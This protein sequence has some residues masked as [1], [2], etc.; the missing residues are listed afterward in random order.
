VERLDALALTGATVYREPELEPL[1][2]SAVLLR[3]GKIAAVGTRADIAIPDDTRVIDCD[4]CIIT[5]G[6]CNAHVH[7]HERK[8]SDVAAIPALELARQLQDITR[9]RVTTCF[10]LSSPLQNTDRLR[11]RIDS[12]EVRGP[13]I[14][15][16]GEGLIPVGGAPSADAFRALGL[17]PAA[18]REVADAT[19]ARDAVR[20]LLEGGADAIKLFLSSPTAGALTFETV[21]AAIDEAH[22]AG[23]LV[24][25]HPNTASDVLTGVDAG[26]DVIAHTTPRSGAWD[27]NLIRAMREHGAALIPTLMLWNDLMRH[28]RLSVREQLAGAAVEQ[29]RAWRELDG[30]VLFGTDLGAVKYD[31][32]EEYQLMAEA[33]MAVPQ[34]LASLTT[35]PAHLLGRASNRGEIRAGGVADIVVL[36]VARLMDARDLASV[37][38]TICAGEIIYEAS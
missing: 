35:S 29:L 20:S 27:A 4:G 37:R 7:F 16:T 17:M 32:T 15:T 33:G 3:N 19:R 5:P 25:A 8:W 26:V 18:L 9:Y 2:D 10:D 14:L 23:K 21:R 31:P 1:H 28:D 36:G 6:F 30:T 38:F 34:I 13:R 12:R 22:D 24:F 11:R